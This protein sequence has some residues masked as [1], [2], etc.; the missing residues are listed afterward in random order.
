[1]AGVTYIKSYHLK[2]FDLVLMKMKGSISCATSI[3]AVTC[4]SGH[5]KTETKLAHRKRQTNDLL[6]IFFFFFSLK[7]SPPNF[8][9]P[10]FLLLFFE[11]N[12][13]SSNYSGW[14]RTPKRKRQNGQNKRV[15]MMNCLRNMG[16]K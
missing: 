11:R 3:W 1:M 9:N 7:V 4:I 12:P 15:E 13:A 8:L 5:Q 6:S 2:N 16:K 14:V 10:N